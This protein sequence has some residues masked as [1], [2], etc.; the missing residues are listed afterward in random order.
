MIITIHLFDQMVSLYVS[1]ILIGDIVCQ[2][3]LLVHKK[4]QGTKGEGAKYLRNSGAKANCERGTNNIVAASCQANLVPPLECNAAI[5]R[6]A[7]AGA[8]SVADVGRKKLG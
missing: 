2:F 8:A 1:V 7:G 6:N 3:Y 5:I 4:N